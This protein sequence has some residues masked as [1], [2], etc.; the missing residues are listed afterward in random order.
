MISKRDVMILAQL[1]KNARASVA[2]ISRSTKIPDANVFKRL[3]VLENEVIK[4]YVTII[5]VS[6]LG[7]C[8]KI[9]MLIKAGNSKNELQD[10]LLKA[11]SVNTMYRI[12]N[13]FDYSA[14]CIFK[15][16]PELYSFFEKINAFD[17]KGKEEHYI[18]E[19]V[20]VEDF[21]TRKTDLRMF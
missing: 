18:L 15:N 4:N 16:I 12:N 14:Y 8:I 10:F 5:D 6:L 19:E 20:K 3:K 2:E 17:I 9:F 11:N 1:R 13:G 21:L 7:Y